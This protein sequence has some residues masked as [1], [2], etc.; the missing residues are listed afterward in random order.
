MG[1][2]EKILTPEEQIH[3][4]KFDHENLIPNYEKYG[5]KLDEMNKSCTKALDMRN[6]FDQQKETIF[7]DA[8]H[9]GDQGNKIIAE[10]I[11]EEILPIINQNIN[12]L[13]S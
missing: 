5:E 7:H 6:A 1:T 9:V 10:K 11:Y 12:K 3:F 2:G 8:G 13:N 4:K